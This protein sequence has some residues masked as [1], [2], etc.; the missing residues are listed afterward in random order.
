MMDQMH[1]R[2]ND[3]TGETEPISDRND[4]LD[5]NGSSYYYDDATGYEIYR[6]DDEEDE[7]EPERGPDEIAG[8]GV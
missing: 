3:H 1:Q 2:G 4:A 6:D 5:E 8:R 7:D